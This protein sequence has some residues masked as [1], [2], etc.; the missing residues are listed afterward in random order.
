VDFVNIT[1]IFFLVVYSTAV[2]KRLIRESHGTIFDR[3]TDKILLYFAVNGNFISNIGIRAT[4]IVFV[5]DKLLC[6]LFLLNHSNCVSATWG[7][8]PRHHS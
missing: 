2:K 8:A 6:I 5:I 3:N 1:P 7:G 4:V